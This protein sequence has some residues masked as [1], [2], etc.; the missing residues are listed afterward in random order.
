MATR[1]AALAAWA[2]QQGLA[3]QV[4]GRRVDAACLQAIARE[5]AAAEA[6]LGE[7]WRAFQEV[8]APHTERTREREA[9]L[10]R[11]V[12]AIERAAGAPNDATAR[13]LLRA[14]RLRTPPKAL[15]LAVASID[16]NRCNAPP[17]P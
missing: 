6:K 2:R 7:V 10:L 4:D 13:A 8:Y 5:Q 11:T 9:F 16:A 14:C 17:G 15:A 12:D 1:L 3:V